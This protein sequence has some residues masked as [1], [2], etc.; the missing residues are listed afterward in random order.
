MLDHILLGCSDLDAG[1]AFVEEHT[2][3]LPVF[4]GVHP[5]RGTRNALLSLGDRHYLE[6]IAPDPKQ[7]STESHSDRL[8]A[9]IKSLKS[10]RLIDWAAHPPDLDALMAKIKKE[11]IVIH[12]P[13]PG[14]RARPDGRVLKWKTADL[15]DDHHGILPFFIEWSPDSTHPSVDAPAGCSLESFLI[16]DPNP[17]E[18]AKTLE[19]LGIDVR[20]EHGD[21]SE[22]RARIRGPKAIMDVT[23]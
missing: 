15:E 13:F 2:G 4:G 22:L 19:R 3:V 5:G 10:P 23:S 21:K 11:G 6:V 12:G 16:A 17:K 18:L 1:I 7:T 9:A 14:S 20:V 8:L